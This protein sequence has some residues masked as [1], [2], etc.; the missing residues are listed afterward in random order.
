MNIFSNPADI[1]FFGAI[2]G[3]LVAAAIFF[4]VSKIYQKNRDKKYEAE[5]LA[6]KAAK[7]T[8]E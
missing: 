4:V 5:F 6:K 7:E 2:G 8:E 1:I 3:L